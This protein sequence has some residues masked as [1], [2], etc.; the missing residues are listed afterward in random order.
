[1]NE[2]RTPSPRPEA[3]DSWRISPYAPTSAQ[4]DPSP[5]FDSL[6]YF[7]ELT[8]GLQDSPADRVAADASRPPAIPGFA[9]LM[10]VGRGGMGVVYRAYETALGRPVAIKM[11]TALADSSALA[12]F[13]SEASVLARLNHPNIVTIHA[14]GE[15]QG[16]P[17][18]VMEWVPGGN[19]AQVC[20]GMPQDPRRSAELVATVAETCQAAHD[21]GII[22]RDLKPG[23]ILLRSSTGPWQPKVADFGLARSLDTSAGLTNTNDIIGTPNYMA[24]EQTWGSRSQWGPGID[25][26]SLGAVLYELLTGR[27]PFV[28]ADVLDTLLLVRTSEPVPPIRL[29]PRLPTDLNTICLKCLEKEP[30]RRYASAQELADDLRRFLAGQP[31]QARPISGWQRSLKWVRRHPSQAALLAILAT[32][33]LAAWIGLTVL[34]LHARAGW[35]EAD[36]QAKAAL[37]GRRLAEEERASAFQQRDRARRAIELLANPTA[38]R[39]LE[40]N[41]DLNP[42]QR[43]FLQRLVTYYQ[44]SLAHEPESWEDHRQHSRAYFNLAALQYQLGDLNAC[45]DAADHSLRILAQAPDSQRGQIDARMLQALALQTKA[46]ALS[47]KGEISKALPLFE[48]VVRELQRLDHAGE[49]NWRGKER[50]ALAALSLARWYLEGGRHQEGQDLASLS[51]QLL[52]RLSADNPDDSSL[53]VKAA[54][55]KVLLAT[56]SARLGRPQESLTLLEEA[57]TLLTASEQNHGRQLEHL[58]AW[59][60]VTSNQAIALNQ[61][62]RDVD[63]EPHYRKSVALAREMLRLRPASVSAKDLLIQSLNGLGLALQ[64]QQSLAQ[65]ADTF[66]EAILLN[67]QQPRSLTRDVMLGGLY[68]NVS[69]ALELQGLTTKAQAAQEK[70]EAVLRPRLAANPTYEIARQFLSNTLIQKA[71]LAEKLASNQAAAC[72]LEAAE[73]ATPALRPVMEARATRVLARMGDWTAVQQ[74]LPALANVTDP[75]PH[76]W[77]ELGYIHALRAGNPSFSEQEALKEKELCLNYLRRA[78]RSRA[79]N[80]LE[81]RQELETTTDLDSLRSWQLFQEFLRE[82]LKP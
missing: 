13:Y 5:R 71:R 50:L 18:M 37:Q 10:E 49:L 60:A 44:E 23:N 1:M 59:I 47:Q 58:E 66:H 48:Q 39:F 30:H 78:F 36:R 24:P 21:Q 63:A 77:I 70:A 33:L 81:R 22:H 54:Q 3:D 40:A 46:S 2:R 43:A 75:H 8:D 52:S 74:R 15:W 53:A 27:P 67:E 4:P 12:R 20:R 61:L 79:F 72:W 76:F 19:L 80:H 82:C 11:L 73:L 41:A 6:T 25:V 35:A 57:S 62:G 68:C 26:Y 28:S 56:A 17:Y 16:H 69:K 65:A 45:L 7:Q 38:M 51:Y 29:Q 14:F 34:Y 55:C 64:R 42:L 31:I 32:V 9:A